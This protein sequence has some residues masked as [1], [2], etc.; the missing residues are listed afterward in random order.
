MPLNDPNSLSTQLISRVLVIA[1]F[2][3]IAWGIGWLTGSNLAFYLIGALG[4]V[5]GVQGIVR[6]IRF[7]RNYKSDHV[8]PYL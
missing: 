7:Q 4:T 8:P 1:L 5:I 6:E 3:G 2:W